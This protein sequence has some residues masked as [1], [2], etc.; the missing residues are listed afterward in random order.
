MTEAKALKELKKGSEAAL[1]WFIQTYTPYVTSIIHGII[2]PFMDTADIEE[3]ASDVFFALWQN[4]EKVYAPKGY[5]GT[6]ARNM[7]KNKLRQLGVTCPLEEAILLINEENPEARLQSRELSLGVRQAVLAMPQPEKD[8]F[9]RHYYY[10]Q[11]LEVISQEM[12]INLSTVKSKLRRGRL[13][14]KA[15]LS[16]YII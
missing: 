8:I 7:A 2:G 10:Y 13:R 14:L 4:A 15:A 3:V 12:G 16:R 6:L 1:E 9:L 5:L 11:T